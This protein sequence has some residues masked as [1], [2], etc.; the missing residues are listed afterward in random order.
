M[1]AMHEMKN[2]PP[3][4][5]EAGRRGCTC[6]VLDNY[7]GQGLYFD[8][9]AERMMYVINET[10]PLHCPEEEDEEASHEPDSHSN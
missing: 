10:C 1:K 4:S 9:E 7:H 5:A 2:A 8:A 6:P 3:G